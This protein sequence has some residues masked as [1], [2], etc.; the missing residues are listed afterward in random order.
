MNGRNGKSLQKK[1]KKVSAHVGFY[2]KNSQFHPLIPPPISGLKIRELHRMFRIDLGYWPS[3]ET[4]YEFKF[5]GE[6]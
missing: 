5:P 3:I 1:K 4:S 6:E 2:T